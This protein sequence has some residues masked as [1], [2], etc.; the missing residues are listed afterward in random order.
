[1]QEITKT[2]STCKFCIE[3][4]PTQR[5]EPL[6]TTPLPGGPWHRIAADLCELERQNYLI[7]TDNYTRDIEIAHLSSTSSHQVISR[8]K[9]MFARWGIP[10]ELVSDNAT[11]FTSGEFQDSC[12]ND[13]LHT[14]PPAL[15]PQVN[16]AV[17][18]AVQTAKRILKQA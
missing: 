7:V 8:L 12:Q 6:I 11:Q 9:G 17:E 14:Q 2:L 3:N 18:Q 16:G 15:S 5:R 10:L 13:G 1:M 4:K